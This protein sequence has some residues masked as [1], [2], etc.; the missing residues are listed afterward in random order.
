M[1]FVI[2]A[3][4]GWGLIAREVDGLGFGF[5]RRIHEDRVLVHRRFFAKELDKW[6]EYDFFEDRGEV[7][8]FSVDIDGKVFEAESLEK[9]E[10]LIA[11]I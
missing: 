2:R 3:E 7:L 9:L 10:A 4:K 5:V 8:A 6:L 11:D 1:A